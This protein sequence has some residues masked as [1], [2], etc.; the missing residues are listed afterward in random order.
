M[1]SPTSTFQ[2]ADFTNTQDQAGG[3]ELKPLNKRTVT[4]SKVESGSSMTYLTG[5]STADKTAKTNTLKVGDLPTFHT[6]ATSTPLS[7]SRS[8]QA[9][10]ALNLTSNKLTDQELISILN[11][12]DTTTTFDDLVEPLIRE[13]DID[14]LERLLALELE[15]KQGEAVLIERDCPNN[16]LE[17][18]IQANWTLGV[19]KC[20]ECE[21][22]KTTVN[23]RPHKYWESTYHCL[24]GEGYTEQEQWG[25]AQKM[26]GAFIKKGVSPDS[27]GTLGGNLVSKMDSRFK[28]AGEHKI[29]FTRD[30]HTNV[31]RQHVSLLLSSLG[32]TI[33]LID[34]YINYQKLFEYPPKNSVWSEP[35]N[36]K[37]LEEAIE[38]CE[39]KIAQLRPCIAIGKQMLQELKRQGAHFTL[40]RKF[41]VVAEKQGLL[42]IAQIEAGE[43]LLIAKCWARGFDSGGRVGE[44]LHIH[45]VTNLKVVNL[46]D[47]SYRTVLDIFETLNDYLPLKDKE[48]MEEKLKEIRKNHGSEL[49]S[50]RDF[51]KSFKTFT[52]S[53]KL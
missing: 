46:S 30:L 38:L 29:D 36:S 15:G 37:V 13:R 7:S 52:Q 48:S 26:H 20:L 25:K 24:N 21:H 32:R 6:N 22:V 18:I 19:E 11:G 41:N 12:E 14:L 1:E 3:I 34:T 39:E 53:T 5:E 8:I 50:E 47:E 33:E 10:Y 45:D 35:N 51:E 43:G 17:L 16:L 23:R 40:L 31:G 44:F 42:R 28:Q 4:F 9:D 27:F 49:P 2:R